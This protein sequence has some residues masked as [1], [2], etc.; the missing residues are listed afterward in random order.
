MTDTSNNPQLLVLA[1]VT[2]VGAVAVTVVTDVLWLII[3]SWVAALGLLVA[4]L[5]GP[6]P[7]EA[8]G[9]T[10]ATQQPDPAPAPHRWKDPGLDEFESRL[11]AR[12]REKREGGG[13]SAG[14]Q[15]GGLP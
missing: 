7:R 2:A 12:V 13:G 5:F 1:L 10:P 9:S 8:Q 4:A 11:D 14:S 6:G 15:G 3:V